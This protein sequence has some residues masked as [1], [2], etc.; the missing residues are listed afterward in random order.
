MQ[1][2]EDVDRGNCSQ[3]QFRRNVVGDAGEPENLN[4]K[5]LAGGLNGFQVFA[6][7]TSEP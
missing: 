4:V 6:A 7:V 3:G 1:S 5:C 2:S